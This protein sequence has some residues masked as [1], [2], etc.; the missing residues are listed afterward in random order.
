MPCLRP[1]TAAPVKTP[2]EVVPAVMEILVPKAP[3]HCPWITWIPVPAAFP[4]PVPV[5]VTA[6][7]AVTLMVS[8]PSTQ[9]P[10]PELVT[11]ATLTVTL[12][13]RP[14]APVRAR[15]P[16]WPCAALPVA[17][18]A[19]V[20]VILMKAFLLAS[21]L[22][23]NSPPDTCPAV[24]VIPRPELVVSVEAWI[25]VFVPPSTAPFAWIFTLPPLEA[26]RIPPPLALVAVAAVICTSPLFVAVA[27][28][29]AP[30][31]P[32]TPPESVRVT[33]AAEPVA[34]IPPA[35]PVIAAPAPLCVSVTV[36]PAFRTIAAESVAVEVTLAPVGML[37]ERAVVPLALSFCAA[38][39]APLHAKAPEP[40]VA[41]KHPGAEAR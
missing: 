40:D 30:V 18:T 6:P 8:P 31:P 11:V 12:P 1:V 13:S 39:A 33:P 2:P 10:C 32:E 36:P 38:V 24:I 25:P 35:A 27:A 16:A 9:I 29:A 17:V 21:A 7:V 22:I 34:A 20:A 15:T 23:P 4:V 37:T 26:P 5:T 14:L 41:S 3:I 19:P 28:I